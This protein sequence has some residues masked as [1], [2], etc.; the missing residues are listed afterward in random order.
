MT[1]EQILQMA[2]NNNGTVTS[3]MIDHHG[4]ARQYLKQLVD[5]GLLERTTRGIYT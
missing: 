4:I 5:K 3:K 1:E 2:E